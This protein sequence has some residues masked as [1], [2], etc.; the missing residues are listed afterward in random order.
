MTALIGVLCSD[1]AVVSTDSASSFATGQTFTIKQKVQKVFVIE[2]CAIVAGSGQVGMG[3][4]FND[5]ASKV[6]TNNRC[7][8]KV[9]LDVARELATEGCKDFA[10]TGAQANSFGAL[11]AFGASKDIHLCE[12]AQPDFQP[13]LKTATTWFVSMGSGQPITDPFLGLMK[14]AF[15]AHK[16]PTLAE[17]I[18]IV[19][20]ALYNVFELCVGHIEGPAQIATLGK[21]DD[22]NFTAK[23]L[24]DEDIAQHEENARGAERHLAKY[25]ETLQGGKVATEEIPAPPER[26]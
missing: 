4:R 18:F 12:F 21:R 16:Q 14:K 26:S 8:T 3:Q 24:S 15:F 23:L 20:W 5:V 1:G 2:N 9:P 19:T 22:G 10:N 6:F 17:G 13:E 25:K 11:L 7:R